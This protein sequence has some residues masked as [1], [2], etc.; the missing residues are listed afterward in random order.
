G[1][2]R[3]RHRAARCARGAGGRRA[4]LR[5]RGPAMIVPQV[6]WPPA[7]P[8]VAILR[9][10]QPV[11]A[12]EVGRI[13]FDAGFRALE[14]PLN[15]P[16]A[17]TCIAAL[18]SLAPPGTCIGAGTVTEPAQVREVARAGARLIISPHF[19]AA[20]VKHACELGLFV[21]PGVFT[22]SEAFAALRAGAHALKI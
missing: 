9:G 2:A 6:T 20:L 12:A 1:A 15:R 10:L 21:A 7:P 11:R 4:R 19:D 16:G 5:A 18:A 17:M 13:L 14:V 8:L 3:L 22:A